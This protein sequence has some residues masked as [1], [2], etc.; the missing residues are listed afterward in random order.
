MYI[1]EDMIS[2][3]RSV[4]LCIYEISKEQMDS[5]LDRLHQRGVAKQLKLRLGCD[6][7]TAESVCEKSAAEWNAKLAEFRIMPYIL[8]LFVDEEILGVPK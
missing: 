5:C 6:T 2:T 3:I 7:K 4:S 1:L 8:K